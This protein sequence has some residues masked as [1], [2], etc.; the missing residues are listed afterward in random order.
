MKMA[1]LAAAV[2]ALAMI[3][4]VARPEGDGDTDRWAQD[5]VE[6]IS[7]PAGEKGVDYAR[8]ALEQKTNVAV[9]QIDDPPVKSPDTN[10]RITTLVFRLHKDAESTDGWNVFPDDAVTACYRADFNYYGVMNGGPSRV[11]CP[12]A[13]PLI[14]PPLPRTLMPSDYQ[15]TLRQILEQNPAVTA[16]TPKLPATRTGPRP[17][18]RPEDP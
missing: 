6:R 7:Y 11:T 4:Y 17:G 10:D 15:G 12:D 5:L 2:L 13:D 8:S 1:A 3:L 16:S 18:D 9:L 14:P